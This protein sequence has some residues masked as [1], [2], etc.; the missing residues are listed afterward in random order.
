VA[1]LPSALMCGVDLSP[2]SSGA[3]VLFKDADLQDDA[4]CPRSRST[5][6]RLPVRPWRAIAR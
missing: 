1:P 3:V 2:G 5:L 6:P 4:A